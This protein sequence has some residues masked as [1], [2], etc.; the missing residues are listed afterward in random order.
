MNLHDFITAHRHDIVIALVSI[1]ATI[2]IILLVI[3]KNKLKWLAKEF[4]KMYSANEIS[5]FSKKRIESGIAFVI[6][7]GGAIF[8]LIHKYN[9]MTTTDFVLWASIQLTIAGWMVSQI[10]KEKVA[11]E[12]EGGSNTNKEQPK[13]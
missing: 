1:V 8:W 5:Y 9:D 10:Q 11:N 7:E 2:L 3:G 6:A 4:S 12:N 13:I